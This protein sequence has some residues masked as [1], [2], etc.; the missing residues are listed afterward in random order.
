MIKNKIKRVSPVWLA[1][2]WESKKR[3]TL[4]CVEAA[5]GSLRD[6]NRSVTLSSI[7][8]EVRLL[9]GRSLSTN[10]IIRNE[11]ANQLYLANRCAPR[12]P[13]IKSRL[14]LEL[15]ARTEPAKRAAIQARVARLRRQAKDDLIVRLMGIEESLIGQMNVANRLREK[16]ILADAAQ[17]RDKLPNNEGDMMQVEQMEREFTY[18]G[19]RLPD[20]GHKLSVDQVRDTYAAAYPEIATA[21]LE[22]PEAVGNNLV[23]RF[24]RA[25]GSKG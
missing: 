22:G 4:N 17:H 24:S 8:G 10:T 15:Y 25:I 19:V 6:A 20:P 23:Y 5:I 14:I 12:T 18:N 21:S 13:Q 1:S 7:R 3:E 11:R 16:I 9:F 2:T